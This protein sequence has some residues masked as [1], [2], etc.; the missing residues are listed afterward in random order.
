MPF[1]LPVTVRSSFD[2]SEELLG[3]SRGSGTLLDKTFRAAE[4]TLRSG[5]MGSGSDGEWTSNR[6]RAESSLW[7]GRHWLDE[8]DLL[9]P[10]GLRGAIGLARLEVAEEARVLEPEG[11]SGRTIRRPRL[12]AAAT[13]VSPR[14][15]TELEGVALLAAIP[16]G[17][18]DA[19][20]ELFD[21]FEDFS[22][23]T[24]DAF[25]QLDRAALMR[26][27]RTARDSVRASRDRLR[28]VGQRLAIGEAHADIR[29]M[30]DAWAKSIK[31]FLLDL[32]VVSRARLA[33]LDAVY[34]LKHAL[35]QAP[36]RL[37]DQLEPIQVPGVLS[38]DLGAQDNVY[39]DDYLLQVDAGGDDTYLNNA[40]GSAMGKDPCSLLQTSPHAAALVDLGGN[41]QYTS[42]RWCGVN[43][44]GFLGSGF[45]LDAEGDDL[46]A[47][48]GIG[49]NG[50]GFIGAGFLLDGSGDD[51]R[52]PSGQDV[53][54]GGIN[55][56]GAIGTGV[57]I[58]GGGND[59][60]D[61]GTD[62]VASNG[63]GFLG[64]LGIAIDAGGNDTYSGGLLGNGAGFLG[65]TGELIDLA[66]NDSYEAELGNA[67]SEEG[68]TSVLVDGE[69]NDLYVS[70]DAGNA[71]AGTGGVSLLVDRGGNDSYQG[72]IA[73]NAGAAF[74]GV[75]LL[76]DTHGRDAYL[77][78]DSLSNG[79][80]GIG[81]LGVLVDGAGNDRYLAED[82]VSNGGG[83]EEG[84]GLLF[85][86]GGN[87]SY[88]TAQGASN[89]GGV[90]GGV[91]FLLD[92]GGHDVYT[93][94]HDGTNGGQD[95]GVGF[96][97]DAGGNDTYVAGNGGTNGGGVCAGSGALIDDAG[98]D[99]YVA[100]RLG[101][102]GGALFPGG[103]GLLLDRGGQDTYQDEE[104]GTGTDCT[105]PAKG[106]LGNQIDLPHTGC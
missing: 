32:S 75:A 51:L 89:G 17:M 18:R 26:L 28:A 82:T 38:V 97:R 5:G 39:R 61:A 53:N 1:P 52:L 71:S 103:T 81:A 78:S 92:G 40:G 3:I 67:S 95:C 19:L 87:D 27:A 13:S 91:G 105:V 65:G 24:T 9:Q 74:G 15:G 98:N 43:G 64:G 33:V 94:G 7:R 6:G 57:L 50:G 4:T 63:A 25:R 59:R 11:S 100:G 20:V 86:A 99:H 22:K 80:G 48:S 34:A 21:A 12:R 14:I 73:S 54:S 45:L 90:L 66:G 56:G 60:Y 88:A 58:D 46:Y 30:P 16:Q 96:L 84:A 31:Q 93:A 83:S 72:V 2:L 69:G 8:L 70:T 55:G 106:V 35:G 10:Q 68:A 79:G 101:V 62:A 23:A 41:D 85:D 76:I 102:N 49:I 104:G 42:G 44:G 29:P 77:A 37:L 36:A 47:A